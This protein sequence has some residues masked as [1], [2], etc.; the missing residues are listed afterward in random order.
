VPKNKGKYR[1]QQPKTAAPVEQFQ[2]LTHRVIEMIR[3]HAVK[4]IS[5]VTGVAVVLIGFSIWSYVQE[6][7]ESNA[8]RQFSEAIARE[9][10]PLEADVDLAALQGET[11]DP[12]VIKYKTANDR[13]QAALAEIEALESRYGSADVGAQGILVKAALAYDLGKWDEAR[14]A[15]QQYLSRGSKVPQLV[16]VAREG[17][18]FTEEAKALAEPDASAR[19]AGLKKALEAYQ[20]VETDEKSPFFAD[21]LYHQGRIT[22]LMGDPKGAVALFKRAQAAHPSPAI[23]DDIETRLAALAPEPEAPASQPAQPAEAPASQPVQPAE[24]PAS[25]PVQPGNPPAAPPGS[26]P[27]HS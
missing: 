5:V 17:I 23:A 24:A 19:N 26:K 6:K 15:Y 1:S 20:Q 11:P 8:T 10:A 27:A 14:A 2:S 18:G 4:L 3:P 7:R 13:T 12:T 22:A 16:V 21:A 25:Q 9:S